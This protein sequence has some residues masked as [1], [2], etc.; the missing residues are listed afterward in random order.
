MLWLVLGP[1]KKTIRVTEDEIN[2]IKLENRVQCLAVTLEYTLFP[3]H[4]AI[5]Y[6]CFVEN[7]GLRNIRKSRLW[8]HGARDRVLKLLP[9]A[10]GPNTKA[11]FGCGPRQS[12]D[13]VHITVMSRPRAAE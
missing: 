4:H 8:Q 2:R 5:V 6:G 1:C 7:I 3:E 13:S 11:F 12:F 9:M 10:V